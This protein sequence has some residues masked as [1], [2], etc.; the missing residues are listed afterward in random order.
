[1]SQISIVLATYNGE[2]YLGRQLDSLLQ[3]TI[4]P[5][6]IVICDDNSQDSTLEIAQKYK[7]KLPLK[8]HKNEVNLGFTKNFESA[9]QKA[10]GDFIL[11]C[12]QDDIW[13]STK[14]ETLL[15]AI[16]ENSLVYANSLLVDENGNSLEKTL[17]QKL[18]NNFISSHSALNFLYDNSVSAH[19]M[20]FKKELLNL[21]FPFPAQTY[22]DAYI[23]ATA[24]S[25]EGV[26]YVDKTLVHY[27]QHTTN[28]LGNK[29]KTKRSLLEKIN[30][31]HAK[32]LQENKRMLQTIE[33]FLTIKT[34]KAEEKEKLQ[35]LYSFY[36]GFEKRWFSFG[37]FLF[38][39]TNKESFFTITNRNALTLSIK[40]SIGFKLYK[41]APFL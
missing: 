27:R 33:E 14:L 4:A 32:K 38:L 15:A 40:K 35:R 34:L 23:A 16:G 31:K 24:A 30:D 6:E 10:T 18:K 36:L 5:Y 8:I 29:K 17:A 37:M 41:A 13:E 21:V 26:V 39:Y 19:A 11:P 20:M 1:M 25:L 22:F 9:L 7:T 3:Q 12:D 2:R 28:T